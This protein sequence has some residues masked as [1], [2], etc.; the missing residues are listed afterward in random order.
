MTKRM[1]WLALCGLT[2]APAALAGEQGSGEKEG[3]RPFRMP[4]AEA[5]AA[6]AKLS[7]DATCSFTFDGRSHQGVCRRGPEGQGPIACAPN[8]DG[9]KRKEAGQ[10]GTA[11]KSEASGSSGSAKP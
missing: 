2:L 11:T 4:P 8:R 7:L 10:G 5:L 3:G 9:E 1:L 6:C